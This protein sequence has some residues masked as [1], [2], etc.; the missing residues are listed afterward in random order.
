MGPLSV[1]VDAW[2]SWGILG[3]LLLLAVAVAWVLRILEAVKFP[4]LPIPLPRVM[5]IGAGVGTFLLIIRGFT[6][7]HSVGLGSHSGVSVGLKL[8]AFL[9]FIAGLVMVAGGVWADRSA[10]KSEKGSPPRS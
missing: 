9:L 5:A 10:P 7:G 3:M 6:Y 4:T 2:H 1:S 8:G